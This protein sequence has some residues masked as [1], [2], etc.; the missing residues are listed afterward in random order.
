MEKDLLVIYKLYLHSLMYQKEYGNKYGDTD[1]IIKMYEEIL[2][3]GKVL[4]RGK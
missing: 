3:K 2:I 1:E 4:K